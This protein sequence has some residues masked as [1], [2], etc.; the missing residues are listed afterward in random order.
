LWFEALTM[1][2]I[3]FVIVLFLL[4]FE[5]TSLA[6]TAP[7]AED[8]PLNTEDTLRHGVVL[9]EAQCGALDTATWVHVDGRGF[10]VRY[11]IS[12][13]GGM[14]DEALVYIPGD[15][16]GVDRGKVFL[17]G[18]ADLS[19][20]GR[21][22]RNA[23]RW[24]NIFGGPFISIGRAGAYGSSGEHLRQR[25]TLLEVRVVMAALDALKERHGFKKF[26][27][28]GKSGGGH[29]L[30][31][32][33][34]TRSD[35]GCAVMTSGIVSVKTNARDLG[36]P[37]NTKIKASYDPIEFIDAIQRRPGQ[38]IVVISDPDDRRVPYH[39]Q[40]EFV[41]RIRANGLPILHVTAAGRD[42][43]AHELGAVGLHLATDCAHGIDDTTLTSRYETKPPPNFA[44]GKEQMP[45]RP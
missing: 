43:Q 30:A 5:A 2:Q 3:I 7:E 38:R 36:W 39:S 45:G 32:L 19:T 16:G 17:A 20:A 14:K 9:S 27:V 22:Q 41:E 31:A 34:Q 11:W 40:R 4:G 18:E 8:P 10:C 25:R 44:L 13:D 24:S 29:T 1:R 42:R 26:N 37:I 12:T 28:V 15:V 33:L 35:L 21:Q 6:Q 23:K